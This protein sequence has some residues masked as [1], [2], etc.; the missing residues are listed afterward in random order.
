MRFNISYILYLSIFLSY[1]YLTSFY[2]IS[3]FYFFSMISMPPRYFLRH[4]GTTMEPSA[5]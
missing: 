2:L 5:R 4:S 1:I 3:K